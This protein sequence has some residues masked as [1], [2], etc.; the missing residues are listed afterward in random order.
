[1]ASRLLCGVGVLATGAL[2]ASGPN[3]VPVVH[4]MASGGGRKV[5]MAAQKGLDPYNMLVPKAVSGTKEVPN[6]V[7]SITKSNSG[8]LLCGTHYK[9]MPC[10]LA[11]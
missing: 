7:P 6:L 4:P 1:M 3:A 11:N 9:L 5:T 2:R 10:Q 8:Q